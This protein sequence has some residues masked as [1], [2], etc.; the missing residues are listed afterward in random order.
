MNLFFIIPGTDSNILDWLAFIISM[1][2]LPILTL[3]T[4]RKVKARLQNRI[5]PPILQPLYDLSKLF[6]KQETIS[7]TMTWIFRSSAAINLASMLVIA[8]FVPWLCFKPNFPGS[9]VFLV[10]YLFAFGRLFTMLAA[11]DAGSAFGAFGASREATLATLV[12]PSMILSLVSLGVLAHTSDLNTIFALTNNN[13]M[14]YQAIWLLAGTA[15][16]LCSVVELS[17]MP[18][19]DPTTHLEL[20]MVHEAMILESS[21]KNLALT[22]YAHALRMSV[23]YGLSAQCYMHAAP[24]IWQLPAVMQ[25]GINIVLL[26]S[27]A[28]AVA[29]FEGVA[30]KLQWLKVPEFIAYS[31]TMSLLAGLLAIGGGILK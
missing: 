4:I 14:N 6:R 28:A 10:I 19:D 11:L 7:Q 9:D 29:I 31:M 26:L 12:E 21:G 18:V 22:E 5:G 27:I 17:R 8:S 13:L 2:F 20:T 15:I 3:G 24:G 23:L 25:A 30:V 1:L 16:L